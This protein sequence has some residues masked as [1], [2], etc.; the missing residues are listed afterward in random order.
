[1]S[2]S[3]STGRS[4]P[5]I[6]FGRAT[7]SSLLAPS[8]KNPLFTGHRKGERIS[9]GLRLDVARVFSDALEKPRRSAVLSS[10]RPDVLT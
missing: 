8:S 1:M 4:W 5:S 3:G 9:A 6:V 10:R 7:G 2:G